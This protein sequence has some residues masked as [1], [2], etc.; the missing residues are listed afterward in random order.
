MF[1]PKVQPKIKEEKKGKCRIRI[2]KSQDGR[3]VDREISPE[4]TDKQI[5]ALLD[6]EDGNQ[7]SQ[8]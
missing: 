8:S 2:R 1:Q 5:K 7:M 4:C 6:S 3:T